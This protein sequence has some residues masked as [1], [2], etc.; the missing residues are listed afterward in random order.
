MKWATA[1]KLGRVSN[2]PTVWTN[3]LTATALVD[4]DFDLL[5]VFLLATAIS[6]FYI[7]GMFLNDVFDLEWDRLHQP[8]RPLVQG[9][10]TARAAIAISIGLL[11]AGTLLLLIASRGG[12]IVEVLCSATALIVLIILYDWKHKQWWVSPW[13]M[14]ACRLM[15]YLTAATVVADWNEK[16]AAAGIC[17]SMYIAGITYA[18][19]A[20]HRNSLNSYWSLGLLFFPVGFVL[21]IGF[22]QLWSTLML[23]V[24]LAWLFDAIR[25][26]LPGP[27]RRIPRAVGALLAGISLID[28][29]ILLGIREYG[30]AVIAACAF[31]L[32]LF[33][34]RKVAAT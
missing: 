3:V 19:R 21:Y 24:L 34:Q 26:L 31:A 4:P 9:E 8:Q 18:A 28:S 16:V 25:R 29:T 22:G 6:F 2:L 11:V 20:E 15:V 14:G 13:I 5:T 12:E 1:L 7:A 27:G 33:A 17:L 23:V 30:A 32:C 10:A